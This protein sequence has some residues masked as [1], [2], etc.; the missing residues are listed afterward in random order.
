MSETAQQAFVEALQKLGLDEGTVVDETVSKDHENGTSEVPDPGG[1][2]VS[3]IWRHPDAHPLV[4]DLMLI[5]KWGPEW[6]LLEPETLQL[7]VPEEFKTTAL[8]DLNLSK[9]QACKTLHATSTFWERWEVF[10]WVTVALNGE[11]P[12]FEVMQVP[13]IAQCLISID[14]ANRIRNDVK[15]S[16]EMTTFLATLQQH[17]GILMSLPPMDFVKVDT[18]H[19]DVNMS[20]VQQRWPSVRISGKAP[21]GDTVEDEQLRRLLQMQEALEESRS[22]LHAQLRLVGHAVSL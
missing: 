21:T 14:I 20:S 17:E 6:L 18:S 12:D 1:I 8:S 13:T 4:L 11:Y 5:R 7:I 15:W 10:D 19:L 2:T 16:T 3:N 9:L 22:R